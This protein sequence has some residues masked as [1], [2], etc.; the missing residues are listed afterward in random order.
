MELIH[1]SVVYVK[2]RYQRVI[3][4]MLHEFDGDGPVIYFCIARGNVEGIVAHEL[5]FGDRALLTD[6]ACRDAVFA[7]ASLTQKVK[8]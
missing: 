5:K 4:H 7:S 6:A 1:R 2:R 8:A 3:V